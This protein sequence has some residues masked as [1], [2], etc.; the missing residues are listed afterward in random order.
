[1]KTIKIGTSESK[2]VIVLCELLGIDTVNIFDEYVKEKVI[3][4]Q[5]EN[6]LDPDGIVGPKTWLSLI[7]I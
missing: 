5:K 2:E 3:E 4:F 6:N 7:H 1:M